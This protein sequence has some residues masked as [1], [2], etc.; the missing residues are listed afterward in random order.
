MLFSVVLSVPGQAVRGFSS[1]GHL[2]TEFF[3]I[4]H[5]ASLEKEGF[6]LAS[7]ADRI[8][9][10]VA[11]ILGTEPPSRRLPVLL[12]DTQ[13]SLNGYSSS[14][15]SNR[16]VI[17]LASA[18]PEGELASFQDELKSVFIHELTHSLGLAIKGPF[19]RLLSAIAGEYMTPVAWMVP[20]AFLEGTAVWIESRAALYGDLSGQAGLPNLEAGLQPPVGRLHDPA[21]LEAVYRDRREGLSRSLWEV[22]GIADHPGAGSLPY[23]Y[24]ALFVEY[25]VDNFGEESIGLLWKESGKGNL[26]AGFTGTLFSK[27]AL[28]T[29]GTQTSREIWDGFLAWLDSKATFLTLPEEDPELGAETFT[30]A[31]GRIG[32]FCADGER[33]AWV[34][35]DRRAVCLRQEGKTSFLFAGD[36]YIESLR[37]SEDGR[38]VVAE[39]VMPDADGYL[40]PARWEWD[41]AKSRF[42]AVT[43][44]E[45]P[46]AGEALANL[47]PGAP[48]PFLHRAGGFLPDGWSYGLARLG[49]RVMPARVSSAGTMELLETTLAGFRSISARPGSAPGQTIIAGTVTEAGGRSRLVLAS[50]NQSGWS[51]F[52]T[53]GMFEGLE[54]P[55]VTTDGSLVFRR[56]DAA[57]RMRLQQTV[58]GFIAGLSEADTPAPQWLPLER[59]RAGIG[60][61]EVASSSGSTAAA[62][63]THAPAVL[64]PRR[65]PS[66]PATARSIESDSDTVAV[67]FDAAD[68]S[69]RLSWNLTTGWDFEAGVPEVE[70]GLSLD[71]DDE[72]LFLGFSD[73][74]YASARVFGL[75]ARWS[76]DLIL[77]PV[78][79]RLALAASLG[80]AGIDNNHDLSDILS[81]KLDYSSA[82]LSFKTA[83]SNMQG[84]RF[85]PFDRQGLSLEL[86]LQ[87]EHLPGTG[88]GSGWEQL[89]SDIAATA[90]AAGIE[91]AHRYPA[92]NLQLHAAGSLSD[93]LLFSPGRRSFSVDG[94]DFISAMS[95]PYP[96]Y[97]E[98][99]TMTGGSHW[100]LFSQ[101]EVRLANL[102]LPKS[103][104]LRLPF[105]PSL[106][107]RRTG[108]WAGARIAAFDP[109]D[110]VALPSSA[111]ARAELDMALLAGLAAEGH[112]GLGM[113]VAWAFDA[114]NADDGPVSLELSLG[115]S[116]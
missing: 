58:P 46:A 107:F 95:L 80:L 49:T 87:H 70:A 73:L 48:V 94:E 24:G 109:G 26:T 40:R 78:H 1:L 9:R 85:A 111:Y 11:S 59:F 51:L 68:L 82:S 20:Q 53:K 116:L 91:V 37:F 65:F 7:Y 17:F 69:E 14:Y 67:T 92:F 72:G 43:A 12:S 108:L 29:L 83:Y 16:I 45:L 41:I 110:G 3:D 27:G 96:L 4:Y 36:G 112:L 101:A 99:S 77:M 64:Q 57:G 52:E 2:R 10:Q 62:S 90:L 114:G 63:P 105:F 22:S 13:A 39:W 47:E 98:Y 6:D 28:G 18:E 5:A 76:R 66:L 23:L 44:R 25:L 81:P 19:W 75:S 102:E 55:V 31:E 32:A 97:R 50:G 15:P 113:E 100:Y 61:R 74:A 38:S 103:G 21:A 8:C 71:I 60:F 88:Q 93:A 104:E 89:S 34:D 56:T 84:G 54:A 79:R 33:L 30:I 106:A 86:A 42:A 115:V 35:L